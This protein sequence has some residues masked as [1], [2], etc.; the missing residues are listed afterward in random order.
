MPIQKAN[1]M[2]STIAIE[3]IRLLIGVVVVEGWPIEPAT[4]AVGMSG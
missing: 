1:L 3:T 2:D 4:V